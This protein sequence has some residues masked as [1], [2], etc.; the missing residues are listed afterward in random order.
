[1]HLSAIFQARLIAK[2]E[3]SVLYWKTSNTSAPIPHL[4]HLRPR[5]LPRDPIAMRSQINPRVNHK[6]H[7]SH[8][9]KLLSGT[10]A[11]SNSISGEQVPAPN[12]INFLVKTYSRRV[13]ITTLKRPRFQKVIN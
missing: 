13:C 6:K 7:Q 10:P 5:N 4:Y 11:L 12:F 3:I 8:T 9:I 1:M 2:N